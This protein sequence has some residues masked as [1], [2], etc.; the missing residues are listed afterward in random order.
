MEG[1]AKTYIGVSAFM[2]ACVCVCV[3]VC[4]C[5]CVCV[6]VCVRVCVYR[7]DLYFILLC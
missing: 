1:W 5:V 2:C 7:R 3:C 4:A 6:C